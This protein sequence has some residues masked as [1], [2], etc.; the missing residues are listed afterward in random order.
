MFPA[1]LIHGVRRPSGRALR[2]VESWTSFEKQAFCDC[3]F[4]LISLTQTSGRRVPFGAIGLGGGRQTSRE[5]WIRHKR[6][7]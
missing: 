2:L 6:K 1:N 4:S 5:S 3:P 7:R